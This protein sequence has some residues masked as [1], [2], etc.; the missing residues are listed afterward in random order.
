M[1]ALS[2]LALSVVAAAAFAGAVALSA[3]GFGMG[4]VALPFMLLVLDPVTAVV[5]VNTAQIPLH[6]VMLRET[7]RQVRVR[8][9]AGLALAGGC[10]AA[11]GAFVLVAS[12]EDALR[13]GA[14]SLIAALAVVFALG[15]PA[16][17][18][19]PAAVGPVLAVGAA[20]L[21]GALGVGGPLVALYAL[22]R[23]WSRDSV[24]GT[25]AAY[26]LAVMVVLV[27]GYAV[28]SLYGPWQLAAVG[29]AAAP[30]LVGAMVGSRLARSMSEETF[31]RAAT[32]LILCSCAAALAWQFAA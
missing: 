19:P 16:R 1:E 29:A 11:L 2:P 31:R 13:I 20:T 22:A 8:Q 6:L 17:L 12:G 27:C 14:L 24:R 7:R 23:G 3:A 15:L 30:A 25:L 4:M 9:G 28:A 21:Q 32:A 10:G 5:A 26:F 18:R